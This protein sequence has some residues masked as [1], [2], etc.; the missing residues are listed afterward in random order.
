MAKRLAPHGVAVGGQAFESARPLRVGRAAKVADMD[1]RLRD[2][3]ALEVDGVHDDGRGAAEH[4]IGLHFADRPRR[5]H[6]RHVL[7]RGVA[8]R[9]GAHGVGRVKRGTVDEV[10]AVNRGL[11]DE[12]VVGGDD[13]L[14]GRVLWR[15]H[16]D[17]RARDG[18]P[19]AV[20]DGAR[21]ASPRV[22]PQAR[23]PRRQVPGH[24]T[25]HCVMETGRVR[26]QNRVPVL[27]HPRTAETPIRSGEEHVIGVSRGRRAFHGLACIE[28]IVPHGRSGDGAAALGGDDDPVEADSLPEP[29]RHGGHLTG[30][31]GHPVIARLAPFGGR[32]HLVS[33]GF[34][35]ESARC[36][37]VRR[38]RTHVPRRHA[39]RASASGGPGR[40]TPSP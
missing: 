38:A 11:G 35:R 14:A 33:P 28:R 12:D 4:G 30:P 26:A 24:D 34:A 16:E 7:G 9:L 39:H 36:P 23:A 13:P 10:R 20:A 22:Q 6:V 1:R 27:G 5:D 3:S 37:R 17:L 15:K 29:E 40:P 31:H 32:V 2:G 18:H 19:V 21:D 25:H 8:G